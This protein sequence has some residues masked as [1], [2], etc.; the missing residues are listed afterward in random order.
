MYLKKRRPVSLTGKWRRATVLGTVIALLLTGPRIGASIASMDSETLDERFAKAA[1]LALEAAAAA[2]DRPAPDSVVMGGSTHS[3][4][5]ATVALGAV[6]KPLACRL[7]GDRDRSWIECDQL[8]T[9]RARER[10]DAWLDGAFSEVLASI[11]GRYGPSPFLL[12]RGPRDSVLLSLAEFERWRRD[13]D[14]PG[15]ILGMDRPDAAARALGAT[16]MMIFGIVGPG[17][18]DVEAR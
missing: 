4:V 14:F 5:A 2:A 7:N 6:S 3:L 8:G 18:I 10:R 9:G 17:D 15:L 11:Q 16:A 12:V 13:Y 1:L